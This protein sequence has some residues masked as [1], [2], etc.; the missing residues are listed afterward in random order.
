MAL[1]LLK[2]LKSL[3]GLCLHI[4]MNLKNVHS[5]CGPGPFLDVRFFKI[6]MTTGLT[7]SLML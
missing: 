2:L 7:S 3:N 4:I 1:V 6:M 5:K